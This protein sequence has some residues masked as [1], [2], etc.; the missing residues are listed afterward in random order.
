MFNLWT[1]EDIIIDKSTGRDI[2]C[3]NV[4]ASRRVYSFISGKNEDYRNVRLPLETAI[5]VLSKFK[6]VEKPV[7]EV[8]QPVEEVEQP[9]EE[10]EQP[11]EEVEQPVEETGNEPVA[12]IGE[13]FFAGFD[14]PTE[15][16]QPKEEEKPKFIVKEKY[17]SLINDLLN[18]FDNS[19]LT[20]DGLKD[21]IILNAPKF[22]H[23][24]LQ[25]ELS[26]Q[27]K[28]AFI[29]KYGLCALTIVDIQI[30][31]TRVR[32]FFE[33]LDNIKKYN[34]IYFGVDS[35]C[36][37]GL[38][39]FIELNLS[40]EKYDEYRADLY[41]FLK[42]KFIDKNSPVY[43]ARFGSD[44]N[45]TITVLNN[46]KKYS[47]RLYNDLLKVLSQEFREK[48]SLTKE[49]LEL[50]EPYKFSDITIFD[51]LYQTW[52]EEQKNINSK[53][54]EETSEPIEE[55][56][57][58]IEETSGPIEETSGP[59][60]TNPFEDSEEIKPS[61]KF[62][63]P[64]EIPE[65][66]TPEENFVEDEDEESY[67]VVR[68]GKLSKDEKIA[69]YVAGASGLLLV[70]TALFGINPKTVWF[71]KSIGGAGA[72]TYNALSVAF[73]ISL[74]YRT[75]KTKLLG[76]IGKNTND[77]YDLEDELD[78]TEHTDDDDTE[79]TDDDEITEEPKQRKFRRFG[80]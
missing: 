57:E 77:Y 2:E 29:D 61:G 10:V 55:T 63:N 34:L 6:P 67:S 18:R 9:V 73:A 28:A 66:E 41:I 49:L 31:F 54:I 70:F 75:A 79:Y 15:E 23:H 14:F 26:E 21:E 72:F 38:Y 40:N 46:V 33:E 53:P 35:G 24:L 25:D 76:L 39:K 48:F 19:N 68:K 43:D 27:I 59:K 78:D 20:I 80:E 7:K 4:E 71:Q 16:E 37:A 47:N 12:E 69:L 65:E 45:Y 51:G 44:E 62:T 52:L 1:D 32:K 42:S 64:F 17:Q 36:I 56:S 58:P 30:A 13:D 5:G 50:K 11:V 22:P 8:E 60:F 3:L 74:V